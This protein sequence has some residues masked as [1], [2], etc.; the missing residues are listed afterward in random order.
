MPNNHRKTTQ[1]NSS[2]NL[3]LMLIDA[4]GLPAPQL[5]YR[6]A[7]PRRWRFDLCWPELL[8]AAEIEGGTWGQGRHSRPQG[9]ERDCE[10]YN[11]AALLGWRVLRFT[12]AMVRDGRALATIERAFSGAIDKKIES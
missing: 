1:C 4:S 8:L 10:K 5:E 6:F 9:Y 11:E 7:P 2:V 12:T 3:I